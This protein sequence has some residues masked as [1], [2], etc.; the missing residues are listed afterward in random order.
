MA[1]L[2]AANLLTSLAGKVNDNV[3]NA[4]IADDW[5][6]ARAARLHT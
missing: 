4:E 3:V 5:R 2:A 1:R 6:S